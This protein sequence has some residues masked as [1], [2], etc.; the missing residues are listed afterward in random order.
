MQ[1][2]ADLDAAVLEDHHVLD[3]LARAE[4]LV[5]MAPHPH[6]R[7]R[8]LRCQRRE[9]AV[10]RIGVDDDLGRPQRRLERGEAIV[11]DGDLEG[12]HR[13]LGL[14]A[15]GPRRV[16]R[17]VFARGQKGAVLPVDRVD[18]LLSAELVEAQLAHRASARSRE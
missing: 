9:G 6:Q 4:L 8:S 2:D 7:L 16:Q 12:G 10:V 11:K 14:R 13:D 15:A 1:G 5:A 17:A 18:D 3:V